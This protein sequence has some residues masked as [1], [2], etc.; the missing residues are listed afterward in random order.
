MIGLGSLGGHVLEFLA[1][2]PGMNRIIAADVNEDWGIRKTNNAIL[3]SVNQGFYSNITFQKIDLNDIEGTVEIL[4]KEKPDLIFNATTFQ[5]WWVIG[6]LPD[7]VY[8]KLIGAG[9]G[10]WLPMHLTLTHKLM[11]AVRKAGIETHVVSSSFPDAVHPVLG[12][13]DLA[14]T[15]G[16]G[17]F[18]LLIPRI[19]RV[20]SEKLK[21]PMRNI[22]VFMIGHHVH[23]VLIEDYGITGGAPYFL[24]ILVDNKNATDKLDPEKIFS[25]PLPTPPG[26]QSDQQV[27]SS[28]VKNILAI[29]NDTGELTHA[30]GPNGLPGGYPVR[31]SAKGAEVVLPEELNLEEAVRINEEAQKFDGIQEIKSDG[32]VVFTEKA[33]RIMREMLSYECEELK[34]EESEERAMELTALYK[35][36]AERY[37]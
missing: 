35:S 32:T 18:D 36:F 10:P 27:A 7:E 28:A 21:V 19:K 9:F 17:N 33:V 2:T 25:E 37:R 16:I 14:P 1:R 23:D 5:S 3:G 26:N 6:L 15:V 29:L 12:K 8:E 31:L 4:R 11:K 24:K 20:V 13:A 34:I 30:P 22:S